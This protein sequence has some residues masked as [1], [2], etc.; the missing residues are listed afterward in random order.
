MDAEEIEQKLQQAV[1]DYA[2]VQKTNT[3]TSKLIKLCW[4]VTELKDLL[5]VCQKFVALYS[6]LQSITVHNQNKKGLLD[7]LRHLYNVIRNPATHVLV[8][9]LSDERR[10]K[11]PYSVP[12]NTSPIV[13]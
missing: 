13:L 4:A 12:S 11:K 8:I 6:S 10:S 3:S 5:T 2:A 1:K 9:M 7:Y